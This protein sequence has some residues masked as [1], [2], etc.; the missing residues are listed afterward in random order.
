ML[1]H[2]KKGSSVFTSEVRKLTVI[3]F[4][5][6][7]LFYWILFEGKLTLDDFNWNLRRRGF[8]IVSES[9]LAD[10][11]ILGG[12]IFLTIFNELI[13]KMSNE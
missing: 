2:F 12:N 10:V 3:F 13:R 5:S 1:A 11:E 4:Q 6:P 9:S 7:A 8:R